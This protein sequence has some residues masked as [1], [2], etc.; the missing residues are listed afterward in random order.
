MKNLLPV[1]LALVLLTGCGSGSAGVIGRADGPAETMADET[2]AVPLL[3]TAPA[4]PISAPAVV[5]EGRMPAKEYDLP[6]EVADMM[7]W[8]GRSPVAKLAE[9]PEQDAAIY[10]VAKEQG[11][12]MLLRWG[13]SLAEFDWNYGGPQI[14]GPQLRYWD[15]DDDGQ[16]EVVLVNH[17]GSGTGVSLDELH[18]VEKQEDG[19]LTDYV[20]PEKLW[21]EQ[22]ASLLGTAAVSGRTFAVLGEELV[23][24]TRH[25]PEGLE[26]EALRGLGTGS[27]ARF[28]TDCSDGTDIRFSGSACL[29]ADGFYY[30]YVADLS[31]DVS[32]AD[33]V[34]TLSNFHLDS[35]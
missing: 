30:C 17:I 28:E 23:D 15:V 5:T 7:E 27:I 26:P 10:G 13:D 24:I 35:N 14:A 6:G 11:T 3:E 21:G 2:G 9:L 20:F 18:I 34:Y 4:R 29:D 22:L 33:G 25:L 8:G 1:L 19:T 32:Y 16:D 31:A 12:A